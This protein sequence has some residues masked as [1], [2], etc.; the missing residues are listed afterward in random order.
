MILTK[1]TEYAIR[2]D[3]RRHK[4]VKKSIRA[5]PFYEI[6]SMNKIALSNKPIIARITARVMMVLRKA[7]D[8]TYFS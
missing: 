3:T 7:A 8:T 2:K 6:S 4:S 1:T 5:F